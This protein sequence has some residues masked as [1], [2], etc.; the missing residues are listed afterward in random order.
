[1]IQRHL[2]FIPFDPR[3]DRSMSRTQ[4]PGSC[5]CPCLAARAQSDQDDA[6]R[7]PRPDEQPE[8]LECMDRGGPHW[9][10]PQAAT[11]TCPLG[12]SISDLESTGPSPLASAHRSSDIDRHGNRFESI[13]R[14]RMDQRPPL[15]HQI[16][17]VRPTLCSPKPRSAQP[18]PPWK[19]SGKASA[20][21]IDDR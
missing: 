18:P 5:L 9:I 6:R 13:D 12:R 19:I 4:R 1:M 14:C 3:F 8:R 15:A 2:A 11:H 7:T 20:R 16:P 10:D 17:A 21:R